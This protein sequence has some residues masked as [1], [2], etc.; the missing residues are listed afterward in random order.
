[1]ARKFVL[2]WSATQGW[3]G[4]FDMCDTRAGDI[5]LANRSAAT[6][7]N[8]QIYVIR[9]GGSPRVVQSLSVASAPTIGAFD[10]GRDPAYGFQSASG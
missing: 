9:L 3:W 7:D 2:N 5:A 4:R 8:S 6:P 10:K 1:M